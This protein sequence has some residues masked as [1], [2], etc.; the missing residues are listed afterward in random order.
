MFVSVNVLVTA[1][2]H[3]RPLFVDFLSCRSSCFIF[4]HSAQNEEICYSYSGFCF[5]LKNKIIFAST[6]SLVVIF[7]GVYNCISC[8]CM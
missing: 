7:I 5:C 2:V 8:G 3:M 6:Y 4:M 1:S